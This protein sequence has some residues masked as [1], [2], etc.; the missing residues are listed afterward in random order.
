[1]TAWTGETQHCHW[2]EGVSGGDAVRRACCDG[3]WA[4]ETQHCD[5]PE[6]LVLLCGVHAV[7]VHGQGRH[8]TVTGL[9]G[10]AV[11]LCG[12]HAVI[13]HGKGDT[14]PSP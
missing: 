10:S 4:R 7:M 12:V 14:A 13:M 5:W 8:S 6:G 1:M 11:M 3:A 2:P 9:W